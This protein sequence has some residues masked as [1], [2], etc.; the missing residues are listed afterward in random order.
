MEKLSCWIAVQPQASVNSM[1]FSE[2]R[3]AFHCC[4]SSRE[5]FGLYAVCTDKSV[6]EWP[7]GRGLDLE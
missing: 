5:G 4:P 3:M 1:A 2:A 7:S 6:F